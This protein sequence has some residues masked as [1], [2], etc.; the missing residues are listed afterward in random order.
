MITISILFK[1]LTAMNFS[2]QKLSQSLHASSSTIN[3]WINK[4]RQ[5]TLS[6]N[7][8]FEHCIDNCRKDYGLYPDEHLFIHTLIQELAISDKEKQYLNGRLNYYQKHN[9]SNLDYYKLF[10]LEVIQA[11]LDRKD[12]SNETLIFD[13]HNKNAPFILIWHHM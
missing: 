1:A 4:D 7:T 13:I 10:M 12:L 11:A 9:P 5:P 8:L 2:Q 6:A 3:A